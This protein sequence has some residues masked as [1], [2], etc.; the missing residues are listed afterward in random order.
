M[1]L[2]P[3]H[4]ELERVRDVDAWIGRGR[5]LLVVPVEEQA[6]V[7]R[8]RRLCADHPELVAVALVSD[9]SPAVHREVLAAGA[10]GAVT[11]SSPPAAIAGAVRAALS[12]YFLLPGDVVRDLVQGT[13]ANPWVAGELDEAER[14]WL[15]ALAAGCSVR[16]LAEEVGYSERT[17]HRRLGNLYRRLGVENR[18]QALT[19]AARCGLLP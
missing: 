16:A 1:A 14:G 13:G 9:P 5:R 8:L 3:L 18:T 17:M 10:S 4:V 6:D 12:G 7:D 2:E 11:D 19:V 15:G